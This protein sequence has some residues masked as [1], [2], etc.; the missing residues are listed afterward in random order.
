M[1]SELARYKR[2][3]PASLK[4]ASAAAVLICVVGEIHLKHCSAL[5]CGC[6]SYMMRGLLLLK[7]A[8]ASIV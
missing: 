2:H 1:E 5:H 6:A 8:C 3:L 7:F 4:H